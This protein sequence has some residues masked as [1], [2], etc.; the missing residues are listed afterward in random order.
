[1]LLACLGTMLF[2]HYFWT[3]NYEIFAE[4]GFHMHLELQFKNVPLFIE[5]K[6]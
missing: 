4:N 5:N 6:H 3:I 1:M 2:L